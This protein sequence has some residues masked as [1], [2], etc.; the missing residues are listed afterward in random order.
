[1]QTGQRA[2]AGLIGVFFLLNGLQWVA[3][4]SAAAQSLGLTLP[5]GIARSS[6]IGDM[7]AFFLGASILILTGAVTGRGAP[8]RAGALFFGLA[9]V[10]R[11]LA[12]IVHGAGFAATFIGVEV[13]V[14]GILLFLASRAD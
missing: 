6:M 2:V 7:G 3:R 13:V 8:L 1:M 11:T 5:D 12:W 10:M 9:A 4:P 14:C